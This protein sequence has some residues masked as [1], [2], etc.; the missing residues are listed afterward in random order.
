MLTSM[1]GTPLDDGGERLL[2]VKT[3]VALKAKPGEGP[4]PYDASTRTM[5]TAWGEGPRLARD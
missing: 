5:T 1:C 2:G 4:G 3:D